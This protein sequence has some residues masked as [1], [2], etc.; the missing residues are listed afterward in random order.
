MYQILFLQG[1]QDIFVQIAHRWR[2]RFQLEDALCRIRNDTVTVR[3]DL[4]VSVCIR[5]YSM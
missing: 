4:R 1:R 3:I 5:S 2:L